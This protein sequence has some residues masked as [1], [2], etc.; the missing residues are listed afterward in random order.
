MTA[1]VLIVG[2]G[3]L[4]IDVAYGMPPRYVKEI[5]PLRK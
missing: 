2:H 3:G 4:R 5:E 1:V